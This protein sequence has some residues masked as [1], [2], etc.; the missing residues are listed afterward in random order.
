MRQRRDP[1]ESA[2]G[3]RNVNY[4]TVQYDTSWTPA[5]VLR[6]LAGYFSFVF[7]FFGYLSTGYP[8]PCSRNRQPL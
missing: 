2:K 5:E 7:K 3:V 4:S 1:C 8:V 6:F